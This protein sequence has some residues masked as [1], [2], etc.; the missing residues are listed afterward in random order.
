MV[1]YK[2]LEVVIEYNKYILVNKINIKQLQNSLNEMNGKD[3]SINFWH[4][5]YLTVNID[6][7]IAIIN[8]SNKI[9][10]IDFMLILGE[11]LLIYGMLLWLV[12]RLLLKLK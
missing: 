5:I 2:A 6:R 7:N 4:R 1:T 11:T 9:V 12:I 8:V 10:F 3:K